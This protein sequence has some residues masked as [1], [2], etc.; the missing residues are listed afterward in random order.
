[1]NMMR[2]KEK[3][4]NIYNDFKDKGM[5]QYPFNADILNAIMHIYAD[6]ED[7]AI[8]IYKECIKDNT[9]FET[10]SYTI[11]DMDNWEYKVTEVNWR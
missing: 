9:D 5:S 6:N 11:S 1:M 10:S 4:E 7:E 3:C 8:E 2:I